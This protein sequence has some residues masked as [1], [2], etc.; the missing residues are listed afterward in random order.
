MSRE[1]GGPPPETMG[2]R[3]R[4]PRRPEFGSNKI[5]PKIGGETSGLMVDIEKTFN[6]DNPDLLQNNVFGSKRP[7]PDRLSKKPTPE[8]LDR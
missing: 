4:K 6:V 2:L 7:V 3:G 1:F 5:V 8:E